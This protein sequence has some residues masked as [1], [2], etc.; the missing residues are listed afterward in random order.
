MTRV[1]V[2]LALTLGV[3]LLSDAA[4]AAKPKF[5]VFAT[6]NGKKFKAPS[7]G[8]A[9]DQ[10]VSGYYQASG[11]VVFGAIECHGRGH[12]RRSRRN[13]KVLSFAC[14]VI[15]N[16]PD[17]PAPTPPFEAPCLAA[18]YAEFRT[19]RFG[20]PVSMTQWLSSFGLGPDG[21]TPRSGVNI[22]VES[23]DGTYVRGAFSGVFDLP[24]Q[25]GTPTQAPISG[26]GQFYFP[27]R[28]IQ[29]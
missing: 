7:N 9:D 26:E 12:R 10:C 15:N 19:G 17:A 24:Q 28:S 27:V 29:P 5:G 21:M 22:R 1:G 25:P 18:G 2:L 23:F 16:P 4:E 11:G 6:I 8:K 20:A 13:P 3:A 14:G